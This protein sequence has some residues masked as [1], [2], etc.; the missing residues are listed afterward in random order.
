MIEIA[1]EEWKS[2]FFSVAEEKTGKCSRKINWLAHLVFIWD[3]LENWISEF[4]VMTN[5][6]FSLVCSRQ[7][8]I[9]CVTKL[10]AL[11][12]LVYAWK[13]KS[14]QWWFWKWRRARKGEL[15]NFIKSHIRGDFNYENSENSFLLPLLLPSFFMHHPTTL[16]FYECNRVLLIYA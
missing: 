8:C 12:S 7:M 15:F 6:Q 16:Q 4:S 10:S 9:F 13:T 1:N 14:L 5:N 2:F 11:I 3:N